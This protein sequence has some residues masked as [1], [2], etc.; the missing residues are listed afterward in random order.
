MISDTW[1]ATQTVK[2]AE[3]KYTI[4]YLPVGAEADFSFHDIAY[5]FSQSSRV[6]Q[7]VP[8]KL[9]AVV[10]SFETVQ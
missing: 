9:E 2:S 6:P 4:D 10:E 8:P 1:Y 5:Y 3:Q 7:E